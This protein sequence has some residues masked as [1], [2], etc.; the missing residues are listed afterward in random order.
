MAYTNIDDPSAYFQTALYTGAGANTS[1][2]NNGNS[3]LKPDFLWIKNRG[4]GYDHVVWDSNRNLGSAT[5]APLL[6]TN[7]TVAE[8]S[9][10]NWWNATNNG[11]NTDGFQF[12]SVE[13]Y[14]MNFTNNTY[15]AWQWKANGGTTSSNTDGDLTSTVQFN[16]TAGFSIVLYTGKSPIEPL[17]VGHGMG[18]APD[19]VLIKNRDDSRNWVMYHKDLTAPAANRYL[20]LDNN[21]YGELANSTLWGNVAPSSTIITTGENASLNQPN[22]DFVAYC[23]KERQ[24]F[25]KFGKYVGNGSTDGTFVY[26][27]FKPAWIMCRR[28]DGGGN[29]W[30]M[31]DSARDPYNPS[32]RTFYAD[33]TGVE[34]TGNNVDLLSNGFKQRD[35]SGNR[36][37]SGNTYIYMAFAENP[38]T[39]STGIPTTAR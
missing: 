22:L 26:T 14:T 16:S 29:S 33:T 17:Q 34:L 24:G 12:G 25:S 8:N 39:T 38:F 6:K 10:Q 23:W 32:G 1:V 11:I 19:V 2:T 15:V 3:A 7:S 30:D 31:H 18:E 27:G 36:N 21:V 20:M 28:I 35:T 13:F 5:N 4:A 9:T 37:G